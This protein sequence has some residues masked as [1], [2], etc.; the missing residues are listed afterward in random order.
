MEK[1]IF[2]EENITEGGVDQYRNTVGQ[3]NGKGSGKGKEGQGIG[4]QVRWK[5]SNRKGKA[6]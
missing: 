4:R 5:R 1:K 6:V 2:L 3:G